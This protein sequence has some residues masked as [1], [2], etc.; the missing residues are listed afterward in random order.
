MMSGAEITSLTLQHADELLSMLQIHG[1]Q[2]FDNFVT[3]I[4]NVCVFSFLYLTF[5]K[6]PLNGHT[7]S[8]FQLRR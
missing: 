4:R 2:H 8:I 5:H 7:N 3:R 6:I 1:S